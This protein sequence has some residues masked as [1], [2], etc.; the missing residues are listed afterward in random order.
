VNVLGIR[1]SNRDYTFAKLS[2]TKKIPQ[3]VDCNTTL[4]PKGFSKPQS[5]KWLLQEIDTLIKRHNIQKIVI[6]GFEG[7][8]C[9]KCFVE[10]VEHEAIV[11]L[12]GASCRV[13][14]VLRKVSSTI[15]KDLGLKGRAHYLTTSLDTSLIPSYDN[16]SAKAKDAILAGWSELP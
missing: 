12:A 8:K 4:Y 16:Y 13:M 6:K 1:C 2:G 14:P 3:V 10:R 5:L 15:A 11:Y 9:D 7:R